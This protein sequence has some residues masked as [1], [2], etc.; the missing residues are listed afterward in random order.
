M[1]NVVSIRKNTDVK[2]DIEG[3]HIY[4]SMRRQSNTVNAQQGLDITPCQYIPL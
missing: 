3:F 2:V 1:F 4:L